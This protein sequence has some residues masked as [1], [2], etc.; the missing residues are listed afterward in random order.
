MLRRKLKSIWIIFKLYGLYKLVMFPARI[1][2]VELQERL[3]GASNLKLPL[4][5]VKLRHR[6]GGLLKKDDFLRIGEN[7]AKDIK[8]M[9]ESSGLNLYNFSKVLDFGCGCARVLRFFHIPSS[10]C[11]FYGTDI[12][13]ELIEWCSK[14][15]HLGQFEVNGFTP[16]TKYADNFFD[17]TYSISVFT[18]LDEEMQLLWL[19]ELHRITRLDGYLLL[20]IHGPTSYIHLPTEDQ[21][22]LATKGFLYLVGQTG[23]L[24]LDG[25]PDFYQSAYH[26][27]SYIQ[28]VWCKYFKIVNH[29]EKGINNHQD[30]ILLQ[31]I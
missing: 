31:K 27:K 23:I 19:K 30:A 10:N 29:F 15:P 12:D 21:K 16:P 24:K 6:V 4:P 2:L 13:R 26:S 18:H 8:T 14:Y 5:P 17:F 9:L 22:I 28:E 3:S 7:C 20:S 25:L 11:K 1:F